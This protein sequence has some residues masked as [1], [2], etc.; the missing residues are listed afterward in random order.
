VQE[1]PNLVERLPGEEPT[2]PT[3]APFPLWAVLRGLLGGLLLYLVLFGAVGGLAGVMAW[4]NPGLVA[5]SWPTFGAV[6]AVGAV[7]FAA[8]GALQAVL[9]NW[10]P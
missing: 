1:E 2:A 3:S 5:W 7:L 9:R 8:G 10:L 6:L 4:R